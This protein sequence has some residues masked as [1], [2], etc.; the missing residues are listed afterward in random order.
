MDQKIGKSLLLLVDDHPLIRRGLSESVYNSFPNLEFHAHST[1]EEAVNS[2]KRFATNVDFELILVLLDFDLPGLMGYEA[3]RE[4]VALDSR[5]KVVTMSGKDDETQVSACIQAGAVGF[6]SKGSAI[7]EMMIAL[8]RLIT[9]AGESEVWLTASG[10]RSFELLPK[11]L[12]L[13]DR[14]R[15]VLEM[16][17]DGLS[18][19]VIAERLGI[20]EVTAKAHLGFL[21]K[22]LGVSSRTQVVLMAQK[23]NLVA[24]QPR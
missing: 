24:T 5:V 22:T 20:S 9:S 10:F 14:Q 23:L 16:V 8:R 15:Q 1:A 11:R 13:S 6:I 17:C 7:D 21:F 2:L 4:V 3:I 18:N 12:E 19:R